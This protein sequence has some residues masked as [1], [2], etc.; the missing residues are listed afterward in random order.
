[1]SKFHLKIINA[2]NKCIERFLA[3]ASATSCFRNLEI[4]E[5]F[6]Q[7]KEL[8]LKCRNTSFQVIE[9]VF[10]EGLKLSS[11]TLKFVS[12][13]LTDLVDLLAKLVNFLVSIVAHL[14][15][16]SFQVTDNLLLVIVEVRTH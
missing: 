2:A 7:S 4:C 12:E 16:K 10:L 15:T 11:Q 14:V 5:G 9:V 1:M 6:L 13:R 3:D 8:L